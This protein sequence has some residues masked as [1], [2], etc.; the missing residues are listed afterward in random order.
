MLQDK[1]W[2]LVSCITQP[3]VTGICTLFRS[4][5]QTANVK[6]NF[7]ILN[8]YNTSRICLTEYWR[9]V[10]PKRILKALNKSIIN[11]YYA[12]ME[13]LTSHPNWNRH[14]TL[15]LSTAELHQ[16]SSKVKDRLWLHPYKYHSSAFKPNF[17]EDKMWM[18]RWWKI[19][20]Q[21]KRQSS[22]QER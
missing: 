2:M 20:K 13:K 9:V 6:A 22:C 16:S 17:P 1:T 15:T 18:R 7:E 4:I 14:N 3:N 10:W 19:K 5:C 21:N 11:E 8:K 12:S